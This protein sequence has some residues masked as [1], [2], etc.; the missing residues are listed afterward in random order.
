MAILSKIS[1]MSENQDL[2]SLKIDRGDETARSSMLGV[3]VG[4]IVMGAAVGAAAWWYANRT[5]VVEVRT[6]TAREVRLGQPTTVLNASGYVTA[7]RMATVSSKVTGRIIEILIEEGMKVEEGQ[8]LATLDP[9]NIEVNLRLA[10]SELV[11]ASTLLIETEVRLHEAEL[12][13][14]RTRPLF[15]RGVVAKAELDRAQANYDSLNARI[16]QQQDEIHVAESR[17]SLW[18]QELSDRQIRAP[19]AGVVVA[20]NAQPGEMISPMSA[21]GSFTRTGIGTIVDMSSLE[22]EV[23]VNESYINRVVAGQPVE[24]TLDAYIDWKIPARVIAIIPTADRQRATVKVRI[25]V[26]E[27][28]PRILPDMGVKVAL[29]EAGVVP[30]PPAVAGSAGS[31]ATGLGV[32][33]P[34]AGLRRDGG[35]DVVFVVNSDDTVE[36]RAVNVGSQND[37]EVIIT[38]GIVSGERIVVE[39]PA[40]LADGDAVTEVRS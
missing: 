20:K 30:D 38:S 35:R 36:R 17:L 2:A 29:H 31:S 23:D 18:E 10:E 21:G 25:G 14:E 6:A 26:D 9:S 34:A 8:L 22:I 16:I 24:A 5:P 27:L 40:D 33:I 4:L 32:A 28:D 7:R 19:F 37:T 3:V 1:T 13:L 12:E 11:A 39:G 15:D